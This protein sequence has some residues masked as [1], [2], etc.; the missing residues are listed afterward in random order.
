[1]GHD[2]LVITKP[3]ATADSIPKGVYV[4]ASGLGFKYL[5]L[6]LYGLSSAIVG[7]STPAWLSGHWWGVTLPSIIFLS[8]IAAFLS[9]RLLRFA[10]PYLEC[11]ALFLMLVGFIS[12]SITIALRT[13]GDGD[14]GR[15]PTALL[16][17]ALMT[18]PW[19]RFRVVN[20]YVWPR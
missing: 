20:E 18:V 12:Y 9:T 19:S 8:G 10:H 11:W 15:L 3:T 14:L 17:I 2:D 7:M 13:V 16:P 4:S 6:A 5:V 1:M